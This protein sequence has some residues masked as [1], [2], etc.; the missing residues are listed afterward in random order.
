MGDLE[1]RSLE[2]VL[3]TACNLNCSY[4]HQ[5]KHAPATIRWAELRDGIDML[6]VSKAEKKRMAFTG[7]EPLL[8][9]PLIQRAVDYVLHAASGG[10]GFGFSLMSNGLLLDRTKLN[11]LVKHGIALQL[12]LD[13]IRQVQELRAPGTFDRVDQ[14]LIEM[15]RNCRSWMRK[16]LSI[17]VVLSS[18]GLPFLSQ[19]VQY[20]FD[21]GVETIRLAPLLTHDEGWG[22]AAEAELKSQAAQ[23]FE[24]SL[25]HYHRTGTVPLEIFR[26]DEQRGDPQPGRRVCR[27]R[28]PG[29]LALGTDGSLSSCLLLLAPEA[30]GTHRTGLLEQ[31]A[32]RADWPGLRRERFS[33]SRRCRDCRFVDTCLVCPVASANIPGNTDFRRVP[34]S[35]CAFNRI[36]GRLRERFPPLTREVVRLLGRDPLPQA[37]KELAEAVLRHE[38]GTM[39][40]RKL[41]PV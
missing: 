38:R 10:R 28:E 21:R 6:L 14:L 8:A 26:H 18:A 39:K 9:W 31:W 12:S 3:T 36:F 27:I 29:A 34:E 24:L 4:C 22:P 16:N 13:G 7:G 2:C 1:L 5:R 20:F 25:V 41:V 30:G 33:S 40:L 37:M 19:S 17:G 15:K 32:A 11:F 23:L 35:N